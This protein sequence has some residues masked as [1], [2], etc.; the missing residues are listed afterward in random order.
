MGDGGSDVSL[1]LVGRE[2]EPSPAAGRQGDS[3]PAVSLRSASGRVGVAR[4]GGRLAVA[5]RHRPAIPWGK[6]VADDPE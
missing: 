6:V 2:G 1:D 5:A 4:L 3:R